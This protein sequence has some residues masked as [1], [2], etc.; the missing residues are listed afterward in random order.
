[1]DR[2]LHDVMGDTRTADDYFTREC[3]SIHKEGTDAVGGRYGTFVRSSLALYN[4]A[5]LER[6]VWAWVGYFRRFMIIS[7]LYKAQM[8]KCKIY[9]VGLYCARS[10]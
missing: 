2:S 7:A 6:G 1:M 3:L 9:I 10:L 5:K 4:Y 8:K